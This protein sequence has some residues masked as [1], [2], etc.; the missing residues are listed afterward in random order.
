MLAE[1]SRCIS[2]LITSTCCFYIQD[3]ITSHLTTA[4]TSWLVLLFLLLLLSY[5][6]LCWHNTW[7][8]GG[9]FLLAHAFEFQSMFR[10]SNTVK[11]IVEV[12]SWKKVAYIMVAR[13][14][15]AKGRYGGEMHPS[16]SCLQWPTSCDWILPAN[17]IF[18]QKFI[19][20]LFYQR[21]PPWSKHLPTAPHPTA[22]GA[23]KGHLD[24]NP[25]HS[26]SAYSRH[27]IL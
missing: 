26:P 22:C 12:V 16:E 20:G 5:F 19:R 6:L 7:L 21:L 9:E 10:G 3:I 15:S 23:L 18:S 4:T 17:S 8:K 24:P 13:K 27:M 2:V 25:W 14:Q 1:T 11:S